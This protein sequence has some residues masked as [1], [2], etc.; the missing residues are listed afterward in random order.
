MLHYK[1]Q[2]RVRTLRRGEQTG[3]KVG[4]EGLSLLAHLSQ[5]TAKGAKEFEEE[6]EEEGKDGEEGAQ[7][8]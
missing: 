8:E 1:V 5:N 2:G 6:E 7:D 3:R 4:D